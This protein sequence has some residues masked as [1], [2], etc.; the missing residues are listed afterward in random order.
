MPRTWIGIV[1]ALILLGILSHI[2]TPAKAVD[3]SLKGSYR[4]TLGAANGRT[5]T[6]DNLTG[7]EICDFTVSIKMDG[8]GD[9][10]AK[11]TSVTMDENEDWDC[12]DDLNGTFDADETDAEDDTL[13]TT[14]RIKGDCIPPWN[15]VGQP[16]S[17]TLT[18]NLDAITD[19]DWV[20]TVQPTDRK[21]NAIAQPIQANEKQIFLGTEIY[22][23][24]VDEEAALIAPYAGVAFHDLNASGQDFDTVILQGLGFQ[25]MD[26]IQYDPLGFEIPGTA[27]DQLTGEALLAVPVADGEEFTL[28]VVPDF[29]LPGLMEVELTL[30]TGTSAPPLRRDS[31]WLASV[32]P[33][34]FNPQTTIEYELPHPASL[35]LE[36]VDIAGRVVRVLREGPAPAGPGSV[37]WDGRDGNGQLSSSGIYFLRLQS[38]DYGESRKIALIK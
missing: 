7:L 30:P 13:G 2:A 3:I 32:H 21:G 23:V 8:G 6:F 26:V 38:E 1:P 37:R 12:D 33:N 34:P 22:F 36:I 5:L 14:A 24:E 20:L 35:R 4:E 18:I 15:G 9:P 28:S 17:H 27:F 19:G 25:V 10:G 29:F 31:P 16:P 11:I